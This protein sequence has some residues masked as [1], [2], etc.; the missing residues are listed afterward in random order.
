MLHG[1]LLSATGACPVCGQD[2]NRTH[3]F[4]GHVLTDRYDCAACG[5]SVYAA[6][7]M[8]A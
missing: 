5:E 1:I 3:A 8:A 6:R 4:N 2:C 7:R